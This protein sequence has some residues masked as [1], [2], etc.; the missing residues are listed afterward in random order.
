MRA[1]DDELRHE[2]NDLSELLLAARITLRAP[3]CLGTSGSG[4]SELSVEVVRFSLPGLVQERTVE[5]VGAANC[6]NEN[7]RHFGSLRT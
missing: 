7:R 3:T 5:A 1:A 4:G 2:G 6:N